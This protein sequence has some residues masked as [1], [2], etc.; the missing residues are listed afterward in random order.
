M[1]PEGLADLQARQGSGSGLAE[2]FLT[3][4]PS[5][6]RVTAGVTN[7]SV[8][9]GAFF[10]A[11]AGA[12]HVS[13]S[14]HQPDALAVYCRARR[15]VQVHRAGQSISSTPN[16]EAGDCNG[17]GLNGARKVPRVASGAFFP[18]HVPVCRGRESARDREGE[19]EI[20]PERSISWH[21]QGIITVLFYRYPGGLVL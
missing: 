15:R 19:A 1:I 14:A 18:P 17:M 20:S 12:R 10:A 11:R 3:T 16:M 7:Q 5:S 9:P 21:T 8:P 6:S 2:S 4:P 13:M